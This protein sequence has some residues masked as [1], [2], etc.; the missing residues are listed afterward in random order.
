MSDRT[1]ENSSTWLLVAVVVA[2]GMLLRWRAAVTAGL[3]LDE[4]V[5]LQVVQHPVSIATLL[6]NDDPT[7]PFYYWLLREWVR[8]FGSSLD[9]ARCFSVLLSTATIALVFDLGRRHLDVESGL[10]AAALCAGSRLQIY[11]GHEVRC[12]ALVGLLCVASFHLFFALVRHPTR[13]RALG[14]ATLNAALLCT[15]YLTIFALAAQAIAAIVFTRYDARFV[16][17]YVSS[18]GISATLF[19]PLLFQAA[20]SAVSE[21]DWIGPPTLG[22]VRFVLKRLA[23]SSTLLT[24][25]GIIAGSVA[26]MWRGAESAATRPYLTALALWAFLPTGLAYAAS[27][28]RQ[29]LL[30]RYVLY[31]SPALYL[32]V[33]AIV[34]LAPIPRR[35]RA[36]VALIVVSVSLTTALADPIQRHDWRPAVAAVRDEQHR[37]TAVVVAP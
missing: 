23:G 5:T 18:L 28:F 34:A 31:S 35:V 15:H 8:L 26:W 9:S 37:G 25:Y 16:R 22:R 11:Y 36:V 20:H 13:A 21:K 19:S 2:A 3:W 1:I 17:F 27:F 12:Y 7:P 6:A 30:D 33:G 4:A 10:I 24:T 32:L 14:V 29:V